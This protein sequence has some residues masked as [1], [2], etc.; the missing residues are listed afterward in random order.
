[1]KSAVWHKGASFEMACSNSRIWKNCSENHH[2]TNGQGIL[3]KQATLKI[4]HFGWPLQ[5]GRQGENMVEFIAK[6]K[7]FAQTATK[8]LTCWMISC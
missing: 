7:V 1:M 8:I 2:R 3:K 4:W 5:R 6:T